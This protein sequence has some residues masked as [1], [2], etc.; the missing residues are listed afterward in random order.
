VAAIS[1]DNPAVLRDFAERRSITFP[2]LSDAGSKVITAFGILNTEVPKGT[3]FAGIP[4]P[5]SYL[6]D[7]AGRVVAKYF[8]DDYTERFTASE[9][10]VHHFG[11]AAGSAHTTSET[12]HLKIASASSAGKVRPGQRIALALD[13]ELKPNMHVYA[14]GVEGGYIPIEWTISSNPAVTAHDVILPP[15]RKLHL[16]AIDETVP[17]YAG[18]F[19]LVR[20]VTISKSAKPGEVTIEGRFRYQACDDRM[21]YIPQNVPLKWQLSVERPDTERSPTPLRKK[22]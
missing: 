17:V 2:L 19:R 22:F 18:S 16:A 9:I 11:A 7:P 14:P 3:A 5:G 12:K 4:Y 13:V 1:Y 8:E 6:V 15:S 21:C 10:L 20:D